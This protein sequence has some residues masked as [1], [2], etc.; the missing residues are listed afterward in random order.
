MAILKIK[1]ENGIFINIPSIKGEKG[2]KGDKGEQGIQGPTGEQ[3]PQGIQGEKGETGAKGDKGDAFTYEDFTAEQ[4]A[5]L[6]GEKGEK[7][8]KGD[9]GT[10]GT[11]GTDGQSATIIIG[12]VTTLEAGSNAIV[13]NVGTENNAIFN[14][15]IP[16]GTDG[17]SETIDLSNYVQS[18]D[19]KEITND[20]IDTIWNS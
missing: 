13:E 17:T 10:N 4:L 3:G 14:F 6:K 1:D 2:E 16:K 7:G 5:S 15:G 20:E 12:T 18:S 11:N 19:L 8:D 9:P